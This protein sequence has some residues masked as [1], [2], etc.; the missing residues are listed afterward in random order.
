M[1][2]QPLVS[3]IMNCFNGDKFLKEAIDSVYKQNFNNWEIIFWDNLSNDK[4]AYIAKSY[5]EKLRYFLSKKHTELGVARNLALKK[6]RGKYIGFLD[7]DDLFI[8]DKLKSQTAYMEGSNH[9]M[10][11]GTSI[12]ID[13]KGNELK[14][15]VA[16]NN[17]G[18][19]FGSLLM[20]YEINM[21]SVLIKRS[22]LEDD[23]LNFDTNLKFNP[24]YNLFMRIASKYPIGVIKKP[25]VKYRVLD[26]SLSKKSISF[27]GKEIRYT[28][29]KL[30]H[31]SKDL[32]VKFKKEFGAA[33][34]KIHYYEAVNSIYSKKRYEALAKLKPII[35]SKI[36]YFILYFLIFFFIPFKV[37]LKIIGR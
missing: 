15:R 26:D 4:S 7:C 10:S 33:Y 16:R 36:E 9:V 28:L 11:Y 24:D 23:N 25:L 32:R 6:A 1:T 35:F 3:I 22:I 12:I 19:I 29:D 21:Q 27:V 31:S 8:K 13:K 18:D 20:H 2:D 37:I 5:N 34:N 14:R 17:S 30:Y